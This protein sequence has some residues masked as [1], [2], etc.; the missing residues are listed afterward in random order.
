[1]KTLA[2]CFALLIASPAFVVGFVCHCLVLGFT[3]GM[4]AV[5]QLL[6]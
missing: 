1:M 3:A 6:K 4:G 5:G 2:T